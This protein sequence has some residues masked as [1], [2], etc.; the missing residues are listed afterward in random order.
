MYIIEDLTSLDKQK[1]IIK[2][3]ISDLRRQID[4]L[5]TELV[6]LNLSRDKL[7]DELKKIKNG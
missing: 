1:E 4:N 7:A 3:S 5:E 2:K 6:G